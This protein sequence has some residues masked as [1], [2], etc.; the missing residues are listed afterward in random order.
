MSSYDLIFILIEMFLS[1]K[2]K[3]DQ[4]RKDEKEKTND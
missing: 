4:L 2:D 3:K 1:Q